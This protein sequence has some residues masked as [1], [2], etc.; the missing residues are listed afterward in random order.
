[1]I[2]RC[3]DPRLVAKARKA[4]KSSRDYQAGEMPADAD[5]AAMTAEEE[6]LTQ[7]WI[8]EMIRLGVGRDSQMTEHKSLKVGTIVEHDGEQYYVAADEGMTISLYNGQSG[9]KTVQRDQVLKDGEP[10]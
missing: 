1:M 5:P 6:A 2:V 8:A 4:L 7:K 3:V 10:V 9:S